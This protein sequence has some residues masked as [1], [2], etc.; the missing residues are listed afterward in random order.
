MKILFSFLPIIYFVGIGVLSYS[1]E[2]F[3]INDTRPLIIWLFIGVVIVL[4]TAGT[5]RK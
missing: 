2:I 1:K 3:G 4:G 5:I